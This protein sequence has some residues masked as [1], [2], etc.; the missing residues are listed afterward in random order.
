VST[1]KNFAIV[2]ACIY[3]I[4]AMI[5]IA[6]RHPTVGLVFSA[7]ALACGVLFLA[8]KEPER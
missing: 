5:D 6:E 8:W 2:A 3:A 1:L 7:F 4:G